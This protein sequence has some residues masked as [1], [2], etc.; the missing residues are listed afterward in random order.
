VLL[1]AVGADA[2]AVIL[3]RMLRVPALA[4]VTFLAVGLGVLVH[5]WRHH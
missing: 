1:L 5:A 2:A 4:V 3:S